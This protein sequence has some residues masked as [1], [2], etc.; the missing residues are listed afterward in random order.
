MQVEYTLPWT[1]PDLFHFLR[2]FHQKAQY[3]YEGQ[4][5]MMLELSSSSV[6][7]G[8][9]L[10]ICSPGIICIHY[11]TGERKCFHFTLNLSSDYIYSPMLGW[12]ES[13]P[14]TKP[15]FSQKTY[16][17]LSTVAPLELKPKRISK[18]GVGVAVGV[19]V[20]REVA[21]TQSCNL[22]NS[23][24]NFCLAWVLAYTY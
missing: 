20:G 19:W 12:K 1:A 7:C 5:S 3:F 17:I 13:Q 11:N 2:F 9:A 15:V 23:D 14:Q 22:S 6:M 16:L 4:Q 21:T 8:E 18:E 24:I 10:E